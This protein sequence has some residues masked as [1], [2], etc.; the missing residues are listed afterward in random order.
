MRNFFCYHLP[1]I[2][3]AA[4]IIVLS[5][6]PKLHLPEIGFFTTDKFL[7]FIE[8]ALFAVL[9]FRSFSRLLFRFGLKYVVWVSLLFLLVFS[10]FDELYQGSIPGR[11]SDAG[12]VL[13]D[14]L[15][16]SLIIFLM[17]RRARRSLAADVSNSK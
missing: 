15:G 5:S 6:I 4:A 14:V 17:W 2:I 12:D 16:A 1:A 13:L 7:H 10:L 11:D 8:Y 9:I 3:Y